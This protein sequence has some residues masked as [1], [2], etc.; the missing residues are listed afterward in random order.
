MKN[1]SIQGDFSELP[2]GVQADY[3]ELKR[4]PDGRICGVHRLIVPWTLNIGID[5]EGVADG[6]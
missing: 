1:Y 2:V 3:L 5:L 4:L 6:Y